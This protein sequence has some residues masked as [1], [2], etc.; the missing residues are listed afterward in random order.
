V[1]F[2]EATYTGDSDA[3]SSLSSGFSSSLLDDL[4]G[5]DTVERV[6][7]ETVATT[8]E[9]DQATV[10]VVISLNGEKKNPDQP[11]RLTLKHDGSGWKV[12]GASKAP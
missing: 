7:I 10:D 1:A 8:T 5:T 2:C 3:A 4:K 11:I 9:G 6:S 12:T